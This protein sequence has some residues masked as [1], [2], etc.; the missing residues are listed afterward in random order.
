MYMNSPTESLVLPPPAKKGFTLIE[1]LVVIAII[2]ILAGLLLPALAKAKDKGLA[3]ACLSNT[4]QIGISMYLY[5]GDHEDFFPMPNAWWTGGP[6]QN[7]WSPPPYQ[8]LTCGGE[9]KGQLGSVNSNANT[10]AP[11]LE[12]YIKNNRVWVCPKRK[13]GL[14]FKTLSGDFDP[15]ITGYLSYGFNEC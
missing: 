12:D 15:S 3:I 6:Y 10:I 11:M 2:A 8:G 14:T 5:A 7:W 1:L 4:K 9:W 13:R